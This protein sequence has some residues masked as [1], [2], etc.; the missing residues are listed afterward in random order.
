MVLNLFFLGLNLSLNHLKT[1]LTWKQKLWILALQK[2]ENIVLQQPFWRVFTIG[3]EMKSGESKES[4]STQ[5]PNSLIGGIFKVAKML[6]IALCAHFIMT[7]LVQSSRN[8]H[9]CLLI[10]TIYHVCHCISY[11]KYQYNS[12]W[13]NQKYQT[14][15]TTSRPVMKFGSRCKYRYKNKYGNWESSGNID[16]TTNMVFDSQMQYSYQN[17]YDIW[18]SDENTNTKQRWHLT[19]QCK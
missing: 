8:L 12:T 3:W 10:K 4:I 11:W 17:N 7:P 13:T 19:E 15:N 1:N 14:P 16:T 2:D 18:Q 5:P 9:N 6:N